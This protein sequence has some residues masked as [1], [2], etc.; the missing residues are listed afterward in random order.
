MP[1]DKL[2]KEVS[3]VMLKQLTL[4]KKV[5]LLFLLVSVF[6]F[7]KDFWEKSNF[8]VNVTEDATFNGKRRSKSY[9]MTYNSG[10]MKL[11]ITAPSVNKGEVYTFSGSKKTIYY[12]SLKQTVTQK[13]EKSEANILSVFN[14]LRGITSKKTQTRNG[15]TFT[16]SNNWLTAIK[17]SGN[18]VNFSDYKSSNGYSYPGKISV[19]DGS[20]QIIYRLSNFR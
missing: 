5:I 8:T 12:P 15:D 7:S 18:T 11:Q 10:T 4:T 20:S 19:S 13:V 2:K 14:K 9:V 1:F 17:S 16:F 3:L 6:S